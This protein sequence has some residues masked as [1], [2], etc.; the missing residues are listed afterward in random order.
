MGARMSRLLLS[1][2]EIALRRAQ[3]SV[4]Y[5]LKPELRAVRVGNPPVR[6]FG[7][8]EMTG[9]ACNWGSVPF[10]GAAEASGRAVGL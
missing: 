1:E 4:A 9:G 6:M 7:F 2:K 3:V 8:S 10:K 5:P